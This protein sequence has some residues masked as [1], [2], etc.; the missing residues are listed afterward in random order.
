MAGKV[1]ES[2]RLGFSQTEQ[3]RNFNLSWYLNL[4]G[5][6]DCMCRKRFS[7]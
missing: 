2:V 1:V 5:D 4:N 3:K 6:K 7:V